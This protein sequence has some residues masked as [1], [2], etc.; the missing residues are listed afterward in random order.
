MVNIINSGDE[1]TKKTI[2]PVEENVANELKDENNVAFDEEKVKFPEAEFAN[3]QEAL[4]YVR[5][6]E[7][8]LLQK[9]REEN[10]NVVKEVSEILDNVEKK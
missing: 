7:N 9:N 10:E 1:T 6:Q 4:E 8:L 3:V 2:N 5:K